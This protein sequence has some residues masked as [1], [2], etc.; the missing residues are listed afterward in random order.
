MFTFQETFV[1][2]SFSPPPQF[3]Q[4]TH[5]DHFYDGLMLAEI[6]IN[7]AIKYPL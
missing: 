5:P 6:Q 4:I 7:T 2:I 1:P 3:T